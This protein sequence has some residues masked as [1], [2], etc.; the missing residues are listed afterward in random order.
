MNSNSRPGQTQP[1]LNHWQQALVAAQSRYQDL[2][3]RYDHLAAQCQ[4]QEQF[5]SNIYDGVNQ[6]IFVIDVLA[7]A[8]NGSQENGAEEA[9][10]RFRIVAFNPTCEALT[11]LANEAIAGKLLDDVLPE[12][13]AQIQ[14]RYQ[15]CIES[16][17]A[18]SYEEK[19]LFQGRESWWLTTLHP[20][21]DKDD[22]VYRLVG[23]TLNI[24]RR[25]QAETA[26]TQLNQQLEQRVQSRTAELEAANRLKDTLL[27]RERQAR[28]EVE[29]AQASLAASERRYR[30]VVNA[31]QEAIFQTDLDGN[32]QFLSSVWTDISG[33]TIAECL[34]TGLWQWVIPADQTDCRNCLQ[35]LISGEQEE[36]LAV[37]R[38]P[39]RRRD[40]SN[41]ARPFATDTD[42]VTNTD[43]DADTAALRED[44]ETHLYIEM[45][46]QVNCGSDGEIDGVSGSLRDITE[47]FRAQ[48]LLQTRAEELTRINAVLLQTTTLL[49]RRNQ[50]LD[51][52]AYVTSHDLKA[53]LRAIANLSTWLEEDLGNQLPADSQHHMHLL[54]GRVQRME[55]LINGLL[56]YSRVGRTEVPTERV[57]VEA[58]LQE[59]LDSLAFPAEFTVD[60]PKT[61][62][63]FEAKRLLLRQVFAN[64]LNNAYKH[65]D[66]ED[67]R[68]QIHWRELAT[69]YEFSISDNGPGID[70][71]YHDRIFS[72][73]QTLKARDQLEST[74]IG[75]SIVRK[76]I[77]SENGLIRVDSELGRGSSF[78]VIWPKQVS[79]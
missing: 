38:L 27:T 12:D 3:S 17:A 18:L 71:Q 68:V 19:L 64:L 57:D 24:D 65:C 56:E 22:Q 6:G 25:K 49:E 2:Q 76:I 30:N 4:A 23:T 5:L 72:V 41:S 28:T 10:N 60:L 45:Y 67:G 43:T 70:P 35:K 42:F 78:I 21:L 14:Q 63:T 74:G 36:T 55:S 15:T 52:F 1:E 50:E 20:L 31:I 8:A 48:Q 59:I 73:F 26:L 47:R 13:A 53:P 32:W 61:F 44:S 62:P 9:Q 40:R 37:F 34:D 69:A 16:R 58:L 46:A 51:Q 75:L 66:R 33:L 11:G 29:L 7:K 54:R 79:S 77:E 39:Q